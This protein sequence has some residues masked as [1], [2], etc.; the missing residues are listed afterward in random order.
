MHSP[1]SVSVVAALAV[2]AALAAHDSTFA[3][4][5]DGA[6]FAR[7]PER[8]DPSPLGLR[9]EANV[10]QSDADVRFIA[11]Y[12]RA[13][14][15][16][17]SDAIILVPPAARSRVPR[18]ERHAR[19][20]GLLTAPEIAAPR[21]PIVIR[22]RGANPGASVVGEA[23]LAAAITSFHG[24]AEGRA[25]PSFGRVRA[26]AAYP[27]VDVVFHPGPRGIELDFEVAPGADPSVIALARD[28]DEGAPTLRS[29]GSLVFGREDPEDRAVVLSPPRTYELGTGGGIV[30]SSWSVSQDARFALGPR[31]AGL[32]LVIDP[33]IDMATY[34]GGSGADVTGI[35]GIALDATGNIYVSG[36]T[37]SPDLPITPGAPD[38]G[39][40]GTDDVFVAKLSADFKT[41]LYGTYLG[42]S[43][44]EVYGYIQRPIAV[45]PAGALYVSGETLSADFPTTVGA[46]ARAS[47]GGYDAFVTK[48][49]PGGQSLVYSTYLGGS[50]DDHGFGLRVEDGFAYVGGYVKSSDFP[51]TPVHVPTFST[52]FVTKIA[53]DGGSLV[54]STYVGGTTSTIF[55]IAVANGAVFAIGDT[56]LDV[57]PATPGAYQTTYG[58]GLFDAFVVKLRTDGSGY[59]YATYLGGDALDESEGIEIDAA[60]NAVI[61]G[62]TQS[63]NFPTSANAFVKTA[64]GDG[65]YDGW[66]AKLDATGA[67]LLYGSYVS[68]PNHDASTGLCLDAQGNAFIAGVTQGG[69][70]TKGSCS[71]TGLGFVQM[72]EPSGNVRFNSLMPE[73]VYGVA[74][75]P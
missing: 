19:V 41:L 75:G 32:P 6:T 25:I 74:C 9:F 40:A 51:T 52:G 33:V 2:L 34:I 65:D 45:D 36:T 8:R 69:L 4:R 62:A 53:R 59:T 27:G 58:G 54:Y 44:T 37:T 35:E 5:V 23:P 21:S 18:A 38:P 63:S 26:R 31:S 28:G 22:L 24:S 14:A 57:F 16:L 43:D 66:V 48:L 20:H 70:K 1:G 56:R 12:G 10:G 72:L 64:G 46:Y 71:P 67:K 29:D 11:R 55:D 7:L 61:V 68:G 13:T 42:G 17:T 60:G 50:G 39:L 15:L 73:Q 49:A 47:K 3:P 30:A